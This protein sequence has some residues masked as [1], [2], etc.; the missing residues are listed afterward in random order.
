MVDVVLF[1]MMMNMGMWYTLGAGMMA[2]RAKH[3][4]VGGKIMAY[5][6]P[7]VWLASSG[8]VLGL[9]FRQGCSTM[10]SGGELHV[11]KVRVEGSERNE[12]E[13]DD[14]QLG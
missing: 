14:E 7:M 4:A 5:V 12:R 2:D 3:C 9:G 11:V 13:D 6:G 10:T 1:G 8:R